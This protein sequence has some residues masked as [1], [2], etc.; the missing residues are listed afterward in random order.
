[1]TASI[2]EVIAAVAA[3]IEAL[4]VVIALVYAAKE[5][6]N[7]AKDRHLSLVFKLHDM[8][9]NP[10]ARAARYHIFTKLPSEPGR[11]NRKDYQM[12]R[13]TWNLMNLLGIIAQR[14]LASKEMILELYSR[15]VVRLWHKLEPHISYY[16]KE[17]GRFAVHFEQLAQVSREYRK[18]HYGEEEPSYYQPKPDRTPTEDEEIARDHELV[19]I[20]D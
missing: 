16:R 10:E 18:E 14:N 19:G 6:H 8:F 17:R 9:D 12:A 3:A 4:A 1:M 20:E 5:L 2:W 7:A 13:N 15:Q 11:L